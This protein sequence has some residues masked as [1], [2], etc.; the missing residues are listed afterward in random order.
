MWGMGAPE[1]GRAVVERRTARS[2]WPR[3]PAARL[4]EIRA[5]GARCT[6]VVGGRWSG[7]AAVRS[8]AVR[9]FVWGWR[10]SCFALVG[11]LPLLEVCSG[12]FIS[13]SS[14]SSTSRPTMRVASASSI[15][16]A[17]ALSSANRCALL[18]SSAAGASLPPLLDAGGN[19]VD[20]SALAGKRVALYFSAGWCPM[21]TSFEPSLMKFVDACKDSGKP[22][23]LIYVASD[24]SKQDAMA[25]AKA[26]DCLQVE[27]DGDARGALK[28]QFNVWSG[29]ESFEFGVFGRRSGVPALVVLS[30]DGSEVAFIDA[31]RRGPG[32]LAKWPLDEAV[33]VGL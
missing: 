19:P 21:C 7:W 1:H 4:I 15:F 29:S 27:Y 5:D 16:T 22:V 18:M 8:S 26:M 32:S 30:E 3:M 28:K 33:W 14:A 6:A 25:R 13:C 2:A 12:R 31:E 10:C 17:V 11:K 9:W 20:A 23:S 24:R